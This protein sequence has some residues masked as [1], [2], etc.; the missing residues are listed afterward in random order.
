[1]PAH[2]LMVFHLKFTYMYNYPY[3]KM[4]TLTSNTLCEHFVVKA[5]ALQCRYVDLTM[6]S[7][8]TSAAN[9]LFGGTKRFW[10]NVE[11]TK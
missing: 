4:S 5:L 2:V 7:L 1:M 10:S 8:F 9:H 11:C 6:H 3:C